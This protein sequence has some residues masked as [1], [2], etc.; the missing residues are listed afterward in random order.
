MAVARKYELYKYARFNKSV[1][2]ATWDEEQLRWRTLVKVEGRKD[3]E[4][5]DSYTVES[6]CIVSGVG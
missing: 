1:T 2:K 3:S 5:G 4:F 6:D